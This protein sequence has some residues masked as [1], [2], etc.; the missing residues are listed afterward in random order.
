M[1]R[2]SNRLLVEFRKLLKFEN[3]DQ[4]TDFVRAPHKCEKEK[5]G[6]YV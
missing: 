3:V 4:V 5:P 1:L 6:C 2:F